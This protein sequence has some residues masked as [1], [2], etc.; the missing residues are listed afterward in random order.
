MARGNLHLSMGTSKHNLTARVRSNST[1]PLHKT[2]KR[3][4]R[5]KDDNKMRRVWPLL[6]PKHRLICLDAN[7]PFPN[8]A[9][10]VPRTVMSGPNT[11]VPDHA[12]RIMV[13]CSGRFVHNA[14]QKGTRYF[15]VDPKAL[16][17]LELRALAFSCC[18]RCSSGSSRCSRIC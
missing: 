13:H 8:V 14:K 18:D 12:S 5:S 9:D 7:R 1:S 6:Q 3:T 10:V 17:G 2:K 15:P 11:L 16:V 4:Q